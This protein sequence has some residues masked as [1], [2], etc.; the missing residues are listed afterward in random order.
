MVLDTT[1]VPEA[2]GTKW[3][4]HPYLPGLVGGDCIPVD[5]YYLVYKAEELGYHPQV[6]LAGRSISISMSGYVERMAVM[7]LNDVG[8]GIRGSKVLMMGRTSKDDVADIRESPVIA[9]V[10]EMKAD[11]FEVYGYDSLLSDEMTEPFGVK[12]LLW[13]DLMTNA[14]IITVFHRQFREMGV[15]E[16]RSLINDVGLTQIEQF[17]NLSK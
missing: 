4:F 6:I 10:R 1:A 9:I 7:D 3:N 5:P 14:V 8:K 12:A 11:T 2:A 17:V 15:S 13:L 16:V